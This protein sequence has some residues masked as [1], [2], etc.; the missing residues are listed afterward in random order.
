MKKS[1]LALALAGIAAAAVAQPV[2]QSGWA[3]VVSVTPLTTEVRVDVPG[4]C[5]EVRHGGNA[6]GA[7]VGAVLGG[8]VG[9]RFGGGTGRA[10][11][12]AAG[13]MGGAILGDQLS[14]GSTETRCTPNRSY[15]EGRPDGYEVVYEYAGVQGRMRTHEFPGHEIQVDVTITPRAASGYRR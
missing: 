10:A 7:V 9:N 15:Y 8:I 5:R 11:A 1:L 2:T 14:G 13:V 3:R 6:S 4:D 12:T